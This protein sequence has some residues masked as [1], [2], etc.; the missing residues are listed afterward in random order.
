MLL[1]GLGVIGQTHA[2]ALEF[3]SE[4]GLPVDVVAGVDVDRA[5]TL[6]F[7]GVDRPVY[8]SVREASEAQLPA[9]VVIATPTG[10][11]AAVCEQAARYFPQ[12]R[13]LVEKPAAATLGDARR[14]LSDI[15]GRQPVDVAYH[16]SFAPE[17]SWG[18]Q[19]LAA[20]RP[21]GLL[22]A[23]SFFADPYYDDFERAAATLGNSWL[24][25]GINALSVLARFATIAKRESLRRI[26]TERQ[27]IFEARLACHRDS[28][29]ARALLV[30]SW[31]AADGAKTTRLRYASGI[32]LLLDHTAVA[33]YLLRDG[34]IE[35][36]FGADRSIRRRD[37]H[38]R[39]LY[40]RWL[41]DGRPT[42]SPETGLHL[43]ELL[44][45]E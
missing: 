10:T 2:R 28:P 11:H 4:S 31:H 30:T 40:Q 21:G 17:V 15:G 12:A 43:H 34:R 7:G 1:I 37:R 6:R 33:A 41:A 35:A 32:E 39:A 8:P 3:A 45:G 20:C 24:D 27:S 22:G 16:T 9:I 26:G 23:E 18:Q 13:L 14:I 36:A 29:P 42:L 44:L 38:Y 25:S 5:R 19:A